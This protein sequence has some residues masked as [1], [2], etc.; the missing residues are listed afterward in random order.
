MSRKLPASASI[1][2]PQSGAKMHAPSAI[3]NA[4]ALITL[5]HD[6]A[7][8]TGNALEIASGTGQHVIEFAAALPDLNWQPSEIDSTRRASI[9]AYVEEVG[10]TNIAPAKSLDATAP[11]W[12]SAHPPQDLM[13]LINLLHLISTPEAATLINEAAIALAPEGRLILYG[14]FKRS[15]VLTSEGDVRFDADLKSA[16]AA[17]GYKDD[18]DIMR[19][20]GD[21]GLN[22]TDTVQM[23]ANN[24]AFIA[25]NANHDFNP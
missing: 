18:L 21:A 6:H 23:P 1:A 14:P 24:L 5:L 4:A 11:G 10:L 8:K 13:L 7:P 20:L 19:M 22:L 12:G 16:D 25:R 9:D 3:R 17:I 15:G 2:T